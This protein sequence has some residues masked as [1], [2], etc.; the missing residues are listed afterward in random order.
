[1]SLAHEADDVDANKLNAKTAG[2]CKV[3][4]L[5][6]CKDPKISAGRRDVMRHGWMEDRY[7]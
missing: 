1:M 4:T 5:N 2:Q 6:P 7:R 3:T